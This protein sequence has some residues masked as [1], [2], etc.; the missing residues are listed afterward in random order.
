M[1][2]ANRTAA[3]AAIA[4][5]AACAAFGKQETSPETPA[6]PKEEVDLATI[7]FKYI[8]HGC[9]KDP[10]TGRY[11]FEIALLDRH[12]KEIHKII[13]TPTAEECAFQLKWI[14]DVDSNAGLSNATLE[15]ELEMKA[16][17]AVAAEVLKLE[18]ANAAAAGKIPSDDEMRRNVGKVVKFV[19]K[20]ILTNSRNGHDLMDWN[21]SVL[22]EARRWAAETYDKVCKKG[23]PIPF[24]F[25]VTNELPQSAPAGRVAVPIYGAGSKLDLKYVD[26]ELDG[27]KCRMLVDTGSTASVVYEAFAKRFL[28]GVKQKENDGGVVMTTNLKSRFGRAEV[29]SFKVGDADFGAFKIGTIPGKEEYVEDGILGIDVLNRVPTL[30]S[31]TGG[32]LVFNPDGEDTAGFGKPERLRGRCNL[33]SKLGVK[34]GDTPLLALIDTGAT[35]S[36]ANPS[37]NWPAET[38]ELKAVTV[39]DADGIHSGTSRIGAEGVIEIGG[40]EIPIHPNLREYRPYRFVIGA[41]DIAKCDMLIKDVTFAFRKATG[42]EKNL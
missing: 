7:D 42:I 41:R 38:G 10:G 33:A 22:T 19:Q 35:A 40:I 2:I 25:I 32:R 12:H 26:C 13:I 17:R 27:H 24:K 21:M 15:E 6:Q 30:L 23:E 20:M 14:P 8:L 34:W 9:V 11:R 5:L 28:G 1:N 37:V 3:I 18:K 29:A 39:Y 16:Y 31:L 4:A 36:T